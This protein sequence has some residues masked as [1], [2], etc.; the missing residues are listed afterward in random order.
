MSS[1]DIV[2]YRTQNLGLA[3]YLL[4]KGPENGVKLTGVS[5]T[6]NRL[7]SGKYTF[8]GEREKIDELVFGYAESAERKYDDNIRLLKSYVLGGKNA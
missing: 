1:Q 5:R 3:A 8:R 2:S 4:T 6:D 7:S